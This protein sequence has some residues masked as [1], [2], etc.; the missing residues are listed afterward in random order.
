MGVELIR[1]EAKYCL[2]DIC[3]HQ[4]LAVSKVPECSPKVPERCPQCHSR[5]WNRMGDQNIVLPPPRRA[6]R[7]RRNL[8][9]LDDDSDIQ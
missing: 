1:V 6:G 8:F 4:W 3:L 9:N 5:K 7:P 2:C